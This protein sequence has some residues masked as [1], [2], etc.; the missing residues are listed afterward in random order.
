ML[1]ANELLHDPVRLRERSSHEVAVLCQML[2]HLSAEDDVA[3]LT[4]F[5]DA[6]AFELSAPDGLRSMNDAAV[7]VQRAAWVA[8]I[9]VDNANLLCRGDSEGFQSLI[10]Q[11]G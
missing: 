10:S 3:R 8:V 5:P 7:P 2:A 1:V 9:E 6:P 4:A 11:R